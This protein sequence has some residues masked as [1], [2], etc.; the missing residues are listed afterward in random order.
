MH[1]NTANVLGQFDTANHLDGKLIRQH[2][3]LLVELVQQQHL[4][5]LCTLPLQSLGPQ[6]A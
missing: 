3:L 6:G 2:E 1:S 4:N 5:T